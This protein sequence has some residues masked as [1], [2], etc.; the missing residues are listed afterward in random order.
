[1]NITTALVNTWKPLMDR[2]NTWKSDTSKTF[3]SFYFLILLLPKK[4]WWMHPP[5]ANQNLNDLYR[6]NY[7]IPDKHAQ[8]N[9]ADPVLKLKTTA[10]NFYREISW[11]FVAVNLLHRASNRYNWYRRVTRAHQVLPSGST[12]FFLFSNEECRIYNYNKA[13]FWTITRI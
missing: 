6:I 12:N 13:N 9:L 3:F 1:M 4:K 8:F 10:L 11:K 2:L 7:E 5:L